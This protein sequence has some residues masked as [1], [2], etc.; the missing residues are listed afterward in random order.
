MKIIFEQS[1]EWKKFQADLL[2]TVRVAN[3]F[4]TEAQNDLE[5]LLVENKELK[6]KINT[7]VSEL[8]KLK[9][10]ILKFQ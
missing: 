10:I 2:T 1:E 7:L 9:V 3:D 4:K 5:R 8:D 6:E